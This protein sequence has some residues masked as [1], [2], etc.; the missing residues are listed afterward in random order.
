[1]QVFEAFAFIK[2][3]KANKN[4]QISFKKSSQAMFALYKSHLPPYSRE[5]EKDFSCLA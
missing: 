1:M 2:Y 4:V 3:I 5:M